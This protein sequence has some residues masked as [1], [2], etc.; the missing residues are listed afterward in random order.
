M[1][2]GLIIIIAGSAAIYRMAEEEGMRAIIWGAAAFT[3]SFGTASVIPRPFLGPLLG[4]VLCYAALVS[5][6]L[7][8]D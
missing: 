6:S 8:R 4:L 2:F 7:C 3:L 5:V 1:Y